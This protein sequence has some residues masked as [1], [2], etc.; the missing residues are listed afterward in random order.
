MHAG[1]RDDATN[2][3]TK[4]DSKR[5]CGGQGCPLPPATPPEVG[6][7]LGGL[8]WTPVKTWIQDNLWFS[9]DIAS[10]VMRRQLVAEPGVSN[11]TPAAST[12][13]HQWNQAV[14]LPVPAASTMMSP[15]CQGGSAGRFVNYFAVV[16]LRGR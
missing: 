11:S 9:N 2:L 12:T 16:V 14:T 3:S 7:F 1:S 4:P 6:R 5:R 15:T 13:L 8:Q 10:E